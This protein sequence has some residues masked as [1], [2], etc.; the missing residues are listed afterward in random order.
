MLAWVRQA[1]SEVEYRLTVCLSSW[2][3]MAW[4][5]V[6][7]H[8]MR[9]VA[10]TWHGIA[11]MHGRAAADR[12]RFLSAARTRCRSAVAAPQV[13]RGANH[14]V[15]RL[16]PL[17]AALQHWLFSQAM[18]HKTVHAVAKCSLNQDSK[19]VPQPTSPCPRTPPPS[20]QAPLPAGSRRWP[21]L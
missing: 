17:R 6:A 10:L 21:G 14:C 8:G 9:N 19:T 1:A 20:P 3:G 12:P 7:R 15:Q 2:R 4:R 11:L 16:V 5:G 13:G 18:L